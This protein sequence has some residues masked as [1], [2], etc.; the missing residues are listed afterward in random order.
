MADETPPAVPEGT[1]DGID[2]LRFPYEAKRAVEVMGFALE[3]LDPG[4]PVRPEADDLVV[5]D[6][7][8]GG[9]LGRIPW[10]RLRDWDSELV[11]RCAA[12]RC[13]QLE[14]HEA[15]RAVAAINNRDHVVNA[16]PDE[17]WVYVDVNGEPFFQAHRRVVVPG[18]PA[19]D[20]VTGDA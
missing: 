13:A 7:H 3:L 20:G 5:L 19:D 12:K 4:L 17:D 1:P 6:R 18:W 11:R 8:T 2:W 10:W 9:V 16:P 15:D 14:L